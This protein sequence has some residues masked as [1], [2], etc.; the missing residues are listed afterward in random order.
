[1]LPPVDRSRGNAVEGI[2]A[3]V[4][5]D[6]LVSVLRLKAASTARSWRWRERVRGGRR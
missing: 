2:V 3:A 5:E 4:V 6:V 1:M